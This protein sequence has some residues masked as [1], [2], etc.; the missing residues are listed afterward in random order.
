MIVRDTPEFV[1]FQGGW[2]IGYAFLAYIPRLI[3]AEKPDITQGQWVTDNYGAPTSDIVS[4][5]G[6]SWVGELFFNFGYPGVIIGMALIGLYFRALRESLFGSQSTVPALLVGVVVLYASAPKLGGALAAPINGI[7]FYGGM[8]MMVHFLV[9]SFTRPPPAA[10]AS[11]PFQSGRG[12]LVGT[13]AK[14]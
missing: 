4:Q 9:R 12:S 14:Q 1:P 6:P 3:W 2:T 7:T 13:G 8:V 5:T 11:T 10:P